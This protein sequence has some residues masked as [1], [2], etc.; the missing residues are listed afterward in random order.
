MKN[1][2]NKEK[3]IIMSEPQQQPVPAPSHKTESRDTVTL[4]WWQ[5][6]IAA[7]VVVALSVGVT[8][9]VN[10]VMQDNAQ[11]STVAEEYKKPKKAEAKQEERPK[12]N[13]RGN[14]IKHIGDVAG[15]Y[16]SQTDKTLVAQWTVNNITI[17]APCTP[18]YDGAPTQPENGHFVLFDVSVETS[19]EYNESTNG[20]LG[21]GV[22]GL[23]TYV[24]KD[25][26][27][28]NG[29][30]TSATSSTCLPQ[31]QQLPG[32]IGPGLKAQGKILFDVPSTDGYLVYDNGWE[33]PLS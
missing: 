5:L 27:Q 4:K 25:G 12:T 24:Q 21:L 29:I 17:D 32:V 1:Q 31:D 6:I 11:R 26:T 23:W 14:L 3:R 7:I 33:Y 9:T 2:P 22:G 19:S 15:I 10:M 8:I 28:W 30:P 13:S 16:K 18:A 20:S